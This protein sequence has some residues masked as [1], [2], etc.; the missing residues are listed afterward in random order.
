M[1]R[2][3]ITFALLFGALLAGASSMPSAPALAKAP[4]VKTQAPGFYRVMVGKFEVTALSDGTNPLPVDQLLT[5]TTPDKV[6]AALAANFLTSPL[7]TSVNTYLINTGARL[8]L[9]DTGAGTFFGPSVGKLQQSLK[10]AGYTPD[11]I[12][13]VF[14]THMH[15]DHVGGLLKGK[16]AAFPNAVI[17]INKADTDFWLSKANLDGAPDSA[18][19]FFQDAQAAVAPYIRSHRFSTFEGSVELVPGI[20]SVPL[21]G[22]TAGHT[23]YLIESDGQSMLMWGDVVHVESIQFADPSVTIAYDSDSDEAA[24]TRIAEFTDAAQKGYLVASSH[25]PFPGLGHVIAKGSAFQWL[26]VEYSLPH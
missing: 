21:A 11:Q 10:A 25:L 12:D 26:P 13:D 19:M 15:P 17:H 1:L 9:I 20:T 4:M 7:E 24:P 6:N 5:H 14:I 18:K 2:R 16:E 22:H 23:G 8:I 3:Q